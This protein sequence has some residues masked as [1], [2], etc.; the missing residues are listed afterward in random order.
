MASLEQ[1]NG[2]YRV[3]FRYGGQ[4]FSRSLKTT[5]Q[6]TARL[7]FD[8]LEDN[9]RRLELGTLILE[10]GA[11][12]AAVLLSSGAISK[13]PKASAR[14]LFGDMLDRYIASIPETS[15]EQTTRGMLGTHVKHLKRLFGIRFKPSEITLEK[16]QAYVNNRA[17]EKGIRG[18]TVS[19]VTIGKELT[20]LK[21]AWSWAG[22]SGFVH[23][24][25]PNRSRLRMPKTEE[26]P[27]F[28]TWVEIERIINRAQL[29]ESE[30][31][32]Y[33]DCVYLNQEE[34]ADLLTDIAA[35][36]VYSFIFPMFA[37][38][39]YTG[40]RRSELLRSQIEDVDLE[41]GVFVIR[42]KKRIKGTRSTRSV[43]ISP[44]L[45]EILTT[46]FDQHPGGRNTFSLT[47]EPLS[48]DQAHDYFV[49]TLENS[50]WD[51]LR[52]W[53]VLRHSFI[54]N[55]ASA[56]VDQRMIDDWV[57]HQT[58]AMRR[59]YRHLFPAKQKEALAAVFS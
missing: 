44:K 17:A 53:H 58:E 27:P 39:A 48:P 16:L 50:K 38:A 34:I 14:I 21:T 29:S 36:E 59:R 13:Q 25:L 20:T 18:R 55:C 22:E 9:L 47:G 52:G 12:V 51:T 57:G 2:F 35:F 42:E 41:T 4:K 56:G 45:S 8:Q 3:V 37:A 43:P 24:E 6:R 26:K 54:S 11:D 46:W 32:D 19:A 15:I 5:N 7:T 1:R 40:A 31:R 23:A 30:A 28:K 33:W 49:R 10:P